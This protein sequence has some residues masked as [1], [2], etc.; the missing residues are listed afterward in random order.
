MATSKETVLHSWHVA[1]GANM[2]LF[3][4]YDMPLWYKTGAKAEHLAVIQ[5]AGIFDTSHMAAVSVQGKG[6]RTLLQRCLSK[7]IDCC[8][9]QGKSP[10]VDGRCVYGVYLKTDGTVI[11]DAIVYQLQAESFMVVV[12]AGMGGEIAGHLV[13]NGG[14]RT[15]TVVDL[16]D[17]V[18]KMDIQGPDSA[19]ILGKILKN[20]AA[21]FER[22][23]Y[24]SCKGGFA[25]LQTSASVELVD[26]TPLLL[27]RTGYTGEFGFELFVPIDRL[28]S[29]W[30]MVLEAGREKGVLACGLAA[31]DSLR[32][33]AVLPLS[34]QDIGPWPFLNNPWPFALPFNDG[35]SG[36]SKDFIGAQ[37]LLQSNWDKYTLPFAGFDPRKIGA[38]SDSFVTSETGERLGSILTCTTDMAIGRVDGEIVSV[39]GN[40]QF[41]AKG[42]CCGFVLLDKQCVPG[43]T[44]ILSDGKRKIKVE[45]R[46]DVRPD[47]TARK[48][49]SLMLG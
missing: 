40:K 2:A 29:V 16:T 46:A 9:G 47:R 10:L 39:A 34:H 5:G 36:F 41:Q 8:L 28:V 38:G 44:V 43:E 6:A 27:S 24:F 13:E 19:R 30:T 42:L 3:G 49:M 33:G 14:E 1:N 22:L 17:R 4:N 15:V 37:A 45:I 18:G 11:D 21:V 23:V 26:G 7:N 31:R 25:D 12:N 35:H 20:P 48:A 32:A